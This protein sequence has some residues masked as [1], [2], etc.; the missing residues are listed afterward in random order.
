MERRSRLGVFLLLEQ[1]SRNWRDDQ[2]ATVDEIEEKVSLQ[3]AKVNHETWTTRRYTYI[4][5]A[6]CLPFKF[7]EL[8]AWR[9]GITN[10]TLSTE[11]LGI[12]RPLV[13]RLAT[14]NADIAN[15]QEGPVRH[16]FTFSAAECVD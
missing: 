4:Q 1:R 15:D 12:L 11:L 13:K 3:T 2:S 9:P 8:S 10:D 16:T 6:V 7:L 5:L 14:T